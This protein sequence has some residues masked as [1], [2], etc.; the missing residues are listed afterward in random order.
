MALTFC[1]AS[2]PTTGADGGHGGSAPHHK[3]APRPPF[4]PPRRPLVGRIHPA[5]KRRFYAPPVR[6]FFASA[7]PS[8]TAGWSNGSTPMRGGDDGEQLVARAAD[9]KLELAV[10]VDRA[11]HRERRGALA[12]LA[13]AFGRQLHVSVGEA[14]Q[15]V[16][17]DHQHRHR[18]CAGRVERGPDCRRHLRRRARASAAAQRTAPMSSPAIVAGSKPTL[19]ST[20]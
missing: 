4:W 9:E 20:E 12:I 15:T 11:E 6:Y 10:L 7:L 19:V 14:L 3:S 8:S 18:L 1:T 17:I 16:G 2:M 13:G 5:G